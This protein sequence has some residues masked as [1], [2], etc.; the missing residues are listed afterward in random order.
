M[1]RR[2]GRKD[3]WNNGWIVGQ[4]IIFGKYGWK[5]GLEDAKKD[6]SG[7]TDRHECTNDKQ[8]DNHG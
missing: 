6:E 3:E 7:W 4:I 2:V 1:E 8:I 5:E